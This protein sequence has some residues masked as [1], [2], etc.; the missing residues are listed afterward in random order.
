M[1]IDRIAIRGLSSL[2]DPQPVIDLTDPAF[3]PAGLIAVTGPTGAGKSTIFDAICLPLY[4][5]TPRLSGRGSDPRELLSRGAASARVELTLRLDDGTRLLATWSANRARDR[6]DGTL[7]PSQLEIRD[8]ASGQVLAAGKQRVLAFVQER[9]GLTFDQ[10]RAVAMLSQGEFARFIQDPPTEKAELLEKL[11]GTGLYARLSMRAHARHARLRQEIHDLEL[12]LGGLASLTAEQ[13]AERQDGIARLHGEL[14]ALDAELAGTQAAQTW[15]SGLATFR[16]R[17]VQV[18]DALHL[19]QTARTAADDERLRLDQAR[20]AQAC[21]APLAAMDAAAV[22]LTRRQAEQEGAQAALPAAER[23]VETALHRVV[24]ILARIAAAH[25]A[26][27]AGLAACRRW[28]VIT[29]GRIAELDALRRDRSVAE[30]ESAKAT[31]A[32]SRHESDLQRAAAASLADAEL[33]RGAAETARATVAVA[34]QRTRDLGDILAGSDPAA[35]AQ[36]AADLDQAIVW[37]MQEHAATVER[38]TD[39]A[40]YADAETRHRA[41][42]V[43][44]GE[45]EAGLLATRQAL[46]QQRS[47]RDAVQRAAS[48]AEFRQFL[49]AGEPCPLCGA[50]EHPGVQAPG[51]LLADAERQIHQLAGVVQEAERGQRTLAVEVQRLAEAAQHLQSTLLER[52]RQATERQAAWDRVR[53][54]LA[55][56][57]ATPSGDAAMQRRVQAIRQR[58]AGIAAAQSARDAAV[59]AATRAAE[60]QAETQVLV[61]RRHS[62]RDQA[63]HAL[64]IAIATRNDLTVRIASLTTELDAGVNALAAELGEPAP[65]RVAHAAWIQGLAARVEQLR[66]VRQVAGSAADLQLRADGLA[67]QVPAG[68]TIPPAAV[69]STID[70][71]ILA[72][73]RQDLDTAGDGQVQAQQALRETVSEIQR[74]RTACAA[75]VAEQQT[76]IDHLQQAALAAQFA[77]VATLRSASLPLSAM[78]TMEQRLRDLDRAHDQALALCEAAEQAMQAHR[79]AAGAAGVPDPD[80]DAAEASEAVAN[81]LAVLGEQRQVRQERRAI[82]QTELAADARFRQEQAVGFADLERLR[83]AIR[84]WADLDALIGHS[85]GDAVRQ[86]AQAMVLDQLLSLANRRLL[87]IAPRYALARVRDEAHPHS[88]ALTVIDHD[89]A[90]EQRPVATL[91][92]GETFLASLALALALADLKRGRLHIGT[93]FIDEGFGSLDADTLEQAMGVLE[94][95][96]AEQGTQILLI[97]HVGALQE[98]IRHQIRVVPQ[99]AGVSRLRLLAP[100]GEVDAPLAAA[101]ERPSLPPAEVATSADMQAV[102][103]ALAAG[104]GTASTRSLRT[105]LDWEMPRLTRVVQ[106]LLDDGRLV[107]PPNS[108]SVALAPAPA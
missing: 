7:Q 70:E 35:L 84:P 73:L 104:G 105:G 24:G 50:R 2:R 83:L 12:R 65:E 81:R 45:L 29:P 1:R 11:T 18:V 63:A 99:G 20:R 77:D 46:E 94:R 62:V 23:A 72:R 19:A 58:L 52:Q 59:A 88:L 67:A 97:S 48:V 98:R 37:A 102:L 40:A 87:A 31:T 61:E 38:H 108:K 92:G 80:A 56:L 96:Q 69:P 64:A 66:M 34:T 26:A 13:I 100:G 42:K 91:S 10:F 68:T 54:R 15:W 28:A 85:T 27:V 55:G 107:R 30:V 74:S 51:G 43:R 36:E 53:Q 3:A 95:L 103:D 82:L 25:A 6:I 90:D 49:V 44:L 89:Q 22:V 4:D 86:V 21:A 76:A 32:V 39:T 8:P 41:Q 106:H 17:L 14:Q 101:A 78:Q 5:A 93:L 47:A 9:L 57:E 71:A 60:Q 33:L 79:T 75:A 16:A